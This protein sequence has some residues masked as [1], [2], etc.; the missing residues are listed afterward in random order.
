MA[1]ANRM[2]DEHPPGHPDEFLCSSIAPVEQVRVM[3]ARRKQQGLTG[4]WDRLW[5]WCLGRVRFE[6][7]RL[8]RETSKS[9]LAW[10]ERYFKAAYESRPPPDMLSACVGLLSPLLGLD[11]ADDER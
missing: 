11:A 3:L 2:I 4:D 7:D 1:I 5:V 10:A 9:T 8:E 6:H